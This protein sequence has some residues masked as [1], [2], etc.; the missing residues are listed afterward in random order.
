MWS[1]RWCCQTTTSCTRKS[2][3]CVKRL[4]EATSS[5]FSI[6]TTP[7]EALTSKN[8]KSP[9]SL[10]SLSLFL[11][12]YQLRGTKL[13]K[14]MT[15]WRWSWVTYHKIIT[16]SIL[17]SYLDVSHI[18]YIFCISQYDIESQRRRRQK[19]NRSTRCRLWAQTQYWR[20]GLIWRWT[21]RYLMMQYDVL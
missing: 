19:P 1:C 12:H 11:V 17:P 8:R 15:I 2:G 16:S 6:S 7:R 13:S 10:L 21:N 18:D 5:S 20:Y 9:T 14:Q 4:I 3:D